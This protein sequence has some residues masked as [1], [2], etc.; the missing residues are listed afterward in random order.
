MSK[1]IRAGFKN[2][3]IAPKKMLLAVKNFKGF[4]VPEAYSVLEHSKRKSDYYLMKILKSAIANAENQGI[5]NIDSLRLTKIVINKGNCL[6]RFRPRAMGRA[7][8]ILK[9]YSH[10]TLEIGL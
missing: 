10:I 6:K 8:K 4:S 9:K 2:A 3:P 7:S 5:T 1:S